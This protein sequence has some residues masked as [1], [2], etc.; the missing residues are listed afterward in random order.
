MSW[1]SLY[2]ALHRALANNNYDEF[3][4]PPSGG[5]EAS[6]ASW[7]ALNYA[8]TC[9]LGWRDVGC[10]LASW[11]AGGKLTSSSPVLELVK[12]VWGTDDLLDYYAAWVWK[13]SDACFLHPQSVDLFK[14]PSPT[15]LAENSM[16]P[17]EDWWRSFCRRGQV[18]HHDPF[19]GGCDSLHLS[20]HTGKEDQVPSPPPI[21]AVGIAGSR[22]CIGHRRAE[23]LD[24]RPGRTSEEAACAGR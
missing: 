4:G 22:V 7:G 17:D 24:R 6:C 1:S 14:G 21:R 11:Y 10:G 5:F 16:W 2:P 9:L 19:Y 18:L 8:L 12:R 3:P 20:G 23:S 15:W 13:P